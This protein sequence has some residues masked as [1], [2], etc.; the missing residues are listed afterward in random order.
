MITP[1]PT[2]EL[3]TSDASEPTRRSA[4]ASDRRPSRRA[5]LLGGAGTAVLVGGGYLGYRALHGDSP[6]GGCDN[7][8][9]VQV[10]A[11]DAIANDVQQA[12]SAVEAKG[13]ACVR[14]VVTAANPGDT[15]QAIV[16]SPS[17]APHVWITDS[18]VWADVINSK[19]GDGWITA[20]D[21]IATSPVV[22]AIPQSIEQ[23]IR[24]QIG[25]DTPSWLSSMNNTLPLSFIDP[26]AWTPT[27]LQ[28]VAATQQ[29]SSTSQRSEL[30][31]S[32]LR[33]S[34][35][36]ATTSTMFAKALEG[37]ASAQLFPASEQQII[38]FN[39]EHPQQPMTF[40]VPKGGVTK[41][42]YQ[43]LTPVR[44]TQPPQAAINALRDELL[45]QQAIT[46]RGVHGFRDP[47]GTP[48][49]A[50]RGVPAS[51]P[52]LPEPKKDVAVSAHN[53]WTNLAK[54][55]RMLVLFDVSGSM[56]ERYANGQS[57][58]DLVYQMCLGAIDA[59][60]RTT[61]LGAWGFSSNLQPGGI[62]YQP[63]V[64]GE[65][66]L[67]SDKTRADLKKRAGV[68]YDLVAR[69]GDT[70]LYDTIDAAFTRINSTYEDT[71]VNSVVVM[72][73]GANDD[74]N[75]GLSLDQ[76]LAR[77]K[78]EYNP[79]RPVKIVTIAIG[80]KADPEALRKIAKATDG[81]SYTTASPDQIVQVF[82]DAFLH[83]GD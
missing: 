69:N 17:S 10:V 75:G 55:A 38:Q 50:G 44:G 37:E 76:L 74:P 81:L 1:E 16:A 77:L 57:K 40:I 54:D 66:V 11:P 47:V 72:T 21:T 24:T 31:R 25:N 36:Q 78:K 20:G 42:Q 67:T 39:S 51:A 8:Q 46:N 6:S 13:E 62:D 80:S 48:L 23:K 32:I 4:R 53:A 71:Y 68:L 28:V 64:E 49:T 9:V 52:Q 5:L 19:L 63:I 29:A 27:L 79:Q 3:S 60:P 58:I 83:R 26:N 2:S 59:L 34:R 65:P 35:G 14:Y 45:T 15:Y 73:D 12:A 30:M 41:L 56:R 18:P 22:I 70:G 7:P 61:R 82:V 43:L 33:L